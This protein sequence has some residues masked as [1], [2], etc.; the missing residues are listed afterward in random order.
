MV[1]FDLE[2]TGL[3]P[4]WDAIIQ[5]AAVRVRGGAV[6]RTE[7]FDT[8]VNP[9]RPVSAFITSYTGITNGMVRG[10]PAPAEALAAFSRFA[11]DAVLLAHNGRRFDVP[12]LREAFSKAG[13]PTRPARCA[14]SI[15]L[16]RAVWKG[17]R[18]HGLD[19]VIERLGMTTQ[20]F[21]RHDAR[22]D[23]GLLAEAVIHMWGRL[24]AD[25]TSLPAPLFAGLLHQA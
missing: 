13:M 2:T 23:V 9:G 15:D 14:D 16:S 4:A 25:F 18:G 3:S 6:V 22:G 5:I 24:A 1:V 19:R 8:F 12:F 11:G 7:A 20:G 10:A 17:I 21:R